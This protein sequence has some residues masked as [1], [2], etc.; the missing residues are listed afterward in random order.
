M[1]PAPLMLNSKLIKQ[2]P[3]PDQA[4]FMGL[5]TGRERLVM[6]TLNTAVLETFLV[7]I[8]SEYSGRKKTVSVPPALLVAPQDG[9]QVPTASFWKY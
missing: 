4:S 3:H 7:S 5:S 9:W 2:A 6:L 8:V 1:Q